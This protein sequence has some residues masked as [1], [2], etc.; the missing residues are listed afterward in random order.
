MVNTRAIETS[1][2]K[3]REINVL[4]KLKKGR[5]RFKAQQ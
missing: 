3:S 5:G 2:F 4:K 1:D